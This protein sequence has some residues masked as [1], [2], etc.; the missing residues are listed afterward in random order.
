MQVCVQAA[1]VAVDSTAIMHFADQY[2]CKHQHVVAP[3][4]TDGN[5]GNKEGLP[6]RKTR[7]YIPADMAQP[8]GVVSTVRVSEQKTADTDGPPA[9]KKRKGKAE[10]NRLKREQEEA[11]ASI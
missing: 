3:V 9:K 11:V 4:W 7:I 10:R 1:A 8:G 6:D 5:L 2:K